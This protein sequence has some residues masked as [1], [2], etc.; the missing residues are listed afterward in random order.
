M[1]VFK[2]GVVCVGCGHGVSDDKDVWGNEDDKEE[3][4]DDD[5]ATGDN[6]VDDDCLLFCVP[7]AKVGSDLDKSELSLDLKRGLKNTFFSMS[8][9]ICVSLMEDCNDISSGLLSRA[10]I[11][12]DEDVSWFKFLDDLFCELCVPCVCWTVD[13]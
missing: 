8:W 11:I 6:I 4:E 10:I 13:M 3:D 9:A 5:V 12:N 7:S 2:K 1:C